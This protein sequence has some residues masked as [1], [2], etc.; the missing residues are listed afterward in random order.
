MHPVPSTDVYI[1]AGAE[2]I[3]GTTTDIFRKVIGKPDEVYK[4]E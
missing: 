1:E 3:S 4:N 2:I